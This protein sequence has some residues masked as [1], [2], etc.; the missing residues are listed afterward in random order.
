MPGVVASVSTD[1]DAALVEGG[2][3]RFGS[4]EDLGQKVTAAKTV[5][6]EVDLTCLALVDVRVPG[7]PALTRNQRC[8]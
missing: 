8:P 6:N 3:I 1:L 7:S 2:A 4:T 5:L